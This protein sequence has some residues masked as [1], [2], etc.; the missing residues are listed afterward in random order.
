MVVKQINI[1]M[2]TKYF[3]ALLFVLFGL[4]PASA[5]EKDVAGAVYLLP[6]GA[7]NV[8][9]LNG[10]W[11]FKFTKESSWTTLKV[12]GETAMQGYAI[13]H[14]V[15]FYYRK[16]V[17]V[18]ANFKGKRVILRFNGVYSH[19]RLTVN[20]HYLR[21][22][23]GGFTRWETD[24]T[25]YVKAGRKAVIELEVTDPRLDVSYASGYAHHPVGGILRSVALFAVPE[26]SLYDVKSE[27]V[28]D[29]LYRDA[30]L[31]LSFKTL[32]KADFKDAKVTLSLSAPDGRKVSLPVS[33]INLQ[34]GRSDYSCDIP[35]S[36]PRKWDAEHPNLYKLH[37]S[38]YSRKG[39]EASYT[40]EIGFRDVR[41]VG[42]RMLVNGR[43]VKLRGACRHDMDPKM[44]RS[45]NARLDSMDAVLAKEANI[46]FIRTSH[47]PP[48]EDF[49]R[50][51]DRLGIYVESETAACFVNTWRQKN[52]APGN[53]KD[54]VEYRDWYLGQ[55]QEEVK[56][57]QSHPSI[58]F[59]SLGNESEYGDNFQA[60]Y[61]WV[62]EYDTTRP[63]IFSYPG[64]D[65][66]DEKIYKILS[67]HYPG[68]DGT[69]EQWDRSSSH[70]E[71][72]GM[73][74]IFDEWAHVPCY[75]YGTLQED[76]NI[77]EFWGKSLDMMWDGVYNAPGALGGAIWG[78]GDEI[79]ELPTPKVGTAWWKE[80]AHTQKPLAYEGR[81]VGYGEWG[82]IDIWRRKKPEFWSTKKAYAPVRLTVRDVDVPLSGTDLLLTVVNRFDHTN[83]KEIKANY[84][85]NGVSHGI[86][87]PAI[88]P[89]E[90]GLVRIPAQAWKEG[91]QVRVNFCTSD[92]KLIN[93]DQ[94]TLGKAQVEMPKSG[95]EGRLSVS[96]SNG[97][98]TISGNGFVVPVNL[99]TGLMEHVKAGG[100]EIIA[101]GP[102]LNA[103]VLYNGNTPEALRKVGNSYQSKDAE[104]AVKQ[105]SYKEQSDGVRVDVE[106]TYGKVSLT[107]T[108]LVQGNG[109]LSLSYA[110]D[111]LP[112]GNCRE[113][114]LRFVLPETY[115]SM[116]WNR[117]GYW[118]AYEPDAFAGH[119]GK[120]DLYK[121]NQRAY[122]Q[123]PAQSWQDDTRD[124]YYWSD[125]GANCTRPLTFKAKGMKEHVYFYT[126]Q[127][128]SGRSLS[129]LSENA[130][131]A[132]RINKPA[133]GQLVLYVNNRWDYPEIGWG[134]YC[135]NIDM[136]PCYGQIRLLL[137]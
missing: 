55:L 13:R 134:D 113:A 119:T 23:N 101:Q 58:L 61:D 86:E 98:L 49:V 66:K 136:L 36:N 72:K 109:T 80:F 107:Y 84:V 24:I 65:N 130:S 57:F 54:S 41:I 32:G 26:H 85:Y 50:M 123:W 64:T 125:A 94:V 115:A 104:W 90:Q 95:K 52:Y 3:Y 100:H 27:T 92:G 28:L 114:G 111:G 8:L 77:R 62:K 6:D 93:T 82:V 38:L 129:V 137:K 25:P 78:F 9:S 53:S 73:P 117:R 48:S 5:S 108:L 132:C 118:S 43:P 79:F 128:A 30:T 20:G 122:G 15:P 110:T 22:H 21:T 16:T 39:L 121:S 40:R 124:Y 44:G 68:V 89:H 12:P 81:C 56:N 67:L 69:M 126:L 96:K 127:A 116:E 131:V 47:Y 112:H 18:P 74:A 45:T 135:K 120:V 11:Q 10:T 1:T 105:V 76:P 133:D 19:A 14:D 34:S 70:F 31:R 106:G 97:L 91:D 46:N 63:T 35:I 37:L 88:N 87:L 59:W 60:T 4:L 71:T 83:L 51:C 33:E 75:V 42:N 99:S 17:T 7:A 2:N 103:S 102:F 29:S